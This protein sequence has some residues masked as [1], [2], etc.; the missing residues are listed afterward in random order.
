MPPFYP[1]PLRS[2]RDGWTAEMQAR[3]LALLAVTGSISDAAE[4]VGMS[5]NGAYRLRRRPGAESFAAAWDAALG[6]PVRKVT[7]N[8]E[9]YLALEGLIQPLIYRGRYLGFKQ[10]P[11][12][13]KLLRMISRLDRCVG[14]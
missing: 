11:N 14:L 6:A 2:R 3:F 4:R 5:R 10:K 13:S 12:N 8:D 9:R 7:V 1:V